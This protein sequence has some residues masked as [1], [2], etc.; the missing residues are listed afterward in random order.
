MKDSASGKVA[1]ADAMPEIAY[2]WFH[3][4]EDQW[5]CDT[6]PV[7]FTL[8]EVQRHWGVSWQSRPS[9]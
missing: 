9:C 7:A 8:H 4:D 3:S 1:R 5:Q 2:G 6:D